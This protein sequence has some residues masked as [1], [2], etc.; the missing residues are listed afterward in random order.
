MKHDST[1]Y[2]V[3]AQGCFE[4]LGPVAGHGYGVLSV[5]KRNYYLHRLS[6][7]IFKGK[8]PN[9]MFVCHRC[10]NPRCFNPD[11]LFL[12]TPR[13]NVED[14]IKKGRAVRVEKGVFKGKRKFTLEDYVEMRR[15]KS[16][17]HSTKEILFTFDVSRPQ[18]CRIL[19]KTTTQ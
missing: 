19:N 1:Q 8:I 4:W 6:Y 9:N 12:G 7:R 17:G 5:F 18:L 10:D 14:M 15:M 2:T 3:N 13:E 16:L 11:H